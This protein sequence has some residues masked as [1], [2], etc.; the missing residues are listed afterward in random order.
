MRVSKKKKNS[1]GRKLTAVA[2][3]TVLLT[4]GTIGVAKRTVS[5]GEKV[6]RVIDGDSFKI[7]NDQTIR[8]S[9]LDAPAVEYCMGKEAKESLT[10]NI[11]GK[12]VIL[13][14]LKTD[15]YGRIMAIVYLNGKNINE[16]MIKNGFARNL[17]GGTSQTKIFAKAN[18]FARK[19]R[20]GIFSPKCYQ[21]VPP[22]P[23]CSIK[24]NIIRKTNT[25]EYIIPSCKFYVASVVEK[26]RGEEWF[27]TEAEAKKAGYVK[28]KS[29]K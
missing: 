26:Y 1:I 6:V 9:G 5:P 25:K 21:T 18:D 10:K 17:S 2:I 3:G 24:G 27:C 20:L 13:K 12:K 28:S 19:E 29:C 23:R 11:L 4:A 14:E 15:M 22:N 16:Y 8:L 7:G